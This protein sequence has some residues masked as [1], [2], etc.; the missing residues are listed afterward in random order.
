MTQ[1]LKIASDLYTKPPINAMAGARYDY[2]E[3]ALATTD[4]VTTQIVAL[5]I[6]PAG[7][8]LMDLFLE[9]EDLDDAS[10]LTV[11]VGILNTYYNEAEAAAA[12]A[13]AYASG[14]ATNTATQPELVSGHNAITA[15][16]TG[17]AKGR[18][19]MT[20]TLNPSRDIGVD[21]AKDRIIAVQFPAA[22]GTPA[23]GDLAIGYLI[24]WT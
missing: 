2:R 4:L 5:G 15:T 12:N 14:G 17:R 20:A 13:A 1:T 9:I 18:A 22:P 7:H 6:L 24:D 3:I 21:Y 10:S 16:T 19:G 23:A 8:R 11:S